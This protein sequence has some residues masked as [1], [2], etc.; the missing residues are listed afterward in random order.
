MRVGSGRIRPE[1]L[2]ALTRTTE[3]KKQVRAV[4]NEIRREAR[5][6]A[7]VATG[8]LRR[9]IVVDNVLDDEGRVVYRV[10]WSPKAWYGLLV[11][12]GTEDTPARP[13]LRPAADKVNRALGR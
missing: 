1:V 6:L 2:V 3:M 10:G 12:L 5:A 4:A 13:H 9:N 8:N 7:P 11:E